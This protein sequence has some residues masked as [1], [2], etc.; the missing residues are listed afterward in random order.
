LMQKYGIKSWMELE[1]RIKNKDVP[2][3][4]VNFFIECLDAPRTNWGIETRQLAKFFLYYNR[5]YLTP[6]VL[7]KVR[8]MPK[9]DRESAAKEFVTKCYFFLLGRHPDGSGLEH[10]TQRLLSGDMSEEDVAV[11]IAESA[12]FRERMSGLSVEDIVNRCYNLVLD[13]N[14]DDSGLRTYDASEWTDDSPAVIASSI[15]FRRVCREEE[16]Q[17]AGQRCGV[18]SEVEETSSHTSEGGDRRKR[19]R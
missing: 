13:R 19:Y 17:S 9:Q 18:S 11:S 6:D 1:E 14:V 8:E 5:E 10:Y 7:S 4:M 3:E 12:E 2:S 15:P 16:E